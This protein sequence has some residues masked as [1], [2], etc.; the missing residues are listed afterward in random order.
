M[1]NKVLA[2]VLTGLI[3]GI[4]AKN[5]EDP[6]AN[7]QPEESRFTKVTLVEKLNE[8]MELEVLDNLDVLFI[9]RAGKIRKYSAA[10]SQIE[11]IGFLEVYSQ[12]ED[13]LLGLA[14]DPKFSENQWIYLYYAPAGEIEI[15]RLSRFTLV[16]G[17]LDN[18]P[19]RLCS[20]FQSS[21]VAATRVDRWSLIPKAIYF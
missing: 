19:K 13:G 4:C 14:K 10:S 5:N 7:L 18:L 6:F 9:E 11:E 21:A 8:P 15:N 12:A 20:K 3:L 17:L 16:D 1:N 2:F